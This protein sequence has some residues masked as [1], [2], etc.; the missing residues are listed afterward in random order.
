MKIFYSLSLFL[1]ILFNSD[2]FGQGTW[3]WAHLFWN[4]AYIRNMS[5]DKSG[6]LYLGGQFSDHIRFDNQTILNDTGN[7]VIIAALNSAGNLKWSKTFKG[8]ITIS[9][10][11]AKETGGCYVTGHLFDSVMFDNHQIFSSDYASYFLSCDSAGN[12]EWVFSSIGASNGI[13]V[14]KDNQDRPVFTGTYTD[15][16]EI[17]GNIFINT[18]MFNEGVYVFKADETGNIIW[19]DNLNGRF[20]FY[21]SKGIAGDNNNNLFIDL[22]IEDTTYLE[23]DTIFSEANVILKYDSTGTQ[24]WVRDYAIGDLYSKSIAIN[25]QGQIFI[26]GIFEHDPLFDTVQLYHMGTFDNDAYIASY[27][28]SFN[29]LWVDQ[30]HCTGDSYIRDINIGS[31][32]LIYFTGSFDLDS[33]IISNSNMTIQSQSTNSQGYYGVYNSNGILLNL[34]MFE[35]DSGNRIELDSLDNIYIY[36]YSSDTINFVP[37][38]LPATNSG[39]IIAKLSDL[40]LKSNY[41]IS[42]FNFSIFP[43]PTSGKLNIVTNSSKE[44]YFNLYN[45]LGTLMRSSIES[46]SIT[47][48]LQFPAGMYFIEL[49]SGDERLVSKLILE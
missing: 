34:E 48:D 37:F 10:I 47:M 38:N 32:N 2:S 23:T 40:Y 13:S 5:S 27:D 29:L 9:S 15:T 25:S 4:N 11:C 26:S 39:G 22:D 45:T 20:S 7:H 35:G 49:I 18:E 31:N 41:A 14:I 16:M 43:N 3:Q 8:D 24:Q 44:Y 6:N 33:L 12:V 1:I 19:S 21:E 36:G 42:D 28:S 17:N 46:G 30:H